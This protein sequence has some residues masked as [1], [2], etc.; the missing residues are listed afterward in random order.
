MKLWLKLCIC[1]SLFFLAVFIGSSVMMIENNVKTDFEHTL[2]RAADEQSSISTGIVW[3][4]V[5]NNAMGSNQFRYLNSIAEYLDSRMNSQ[6][7]YTVIRDEK[8]VLY[9]NLDIPFPVS[10]INGSQA[11]TAQYKVQEAEGKKYLCLTSRVRFKEIDFYNTYILDVSAI[12]EDRMQQYLYFIRLALLVL[13]LLAGG[14]YFIT[15][16]LTKSIRI[17]T[18]SV[19]KMAGGDYQER[20]VIR[21]KDEV[22]QL[23]DRYNEMAEA[24]E[25][26]IVQLQ[27]KTEQQQRFIGNFTH[28]LRT[29]LTAVVGYADL[30]RSTSGDEELT[31]EMGERIFR[32][33]KRIEKLSKLMMDLAFLENHTF[34]F[35]PCDV[36]KL[37]TEAADLSAHALETAGMKLI[38][39]LP[40]QGTMLSV[41]QGLI[42]NLLGNLI[43]NARKAS[44]TG[45]TIWL[46]CRK[47]AE[48]IILEVEDQGKGIPEEER[49]KVFEAFYMLDKVRNRK[50]NG[51]GLGLSICADIAKVHEAVIEL[52]GREGEGT[53]IKITFPCYKL[54]T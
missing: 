50:N 42:L 41:E 45:D 4:V 25:G 14:M 29:P 53:I 27:R 16:R 37:L 52:A 3:Y 31:Q 12:Y 9:S 48:S 11:E 7:I 21:S 28:E 2:R 10:Q 46:R 19:K 8:E 40:E 1:S 30:L 5:R 6:G 47:E 35:V 13:V 39:V 54:D 36:G 38:T 44:K 17:L 34:E 24:I 43:D 26:K 18:K 23:A 49:E 33:G 22:G 32:E 20:V 51:I 15:G